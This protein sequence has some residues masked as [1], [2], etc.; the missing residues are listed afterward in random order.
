VK[1]P[2]L[3]LCLVTALALLVPSA[4]FAEPAESVEPTTLDE[5]EASAEPPQE[6]GFGVSVSTALNGEV[7]P[8]RLIAAGL[9]YFDM[10][11]FELG[12]GFHPFIRDE[13]TIVSG[14]F[15]Y[16]LF[17]N[18]RSNKFKTYLL[19]NLSYIY[20]S[21][22]TFYPTSYHYLFLHGGY[23]LELAGFAGSYMDTNVSF[24]G[25]TY[26]KNSQNP[27]ASLLDADSF[28]EDFGFSISFQ[29]SV[30]YRF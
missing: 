2:Y 9:Y 23:G 18:G 26:N 28:F 15:N 17:P 6:S 25:F 1:I 16:K 4:A 12:V 3:M 11:Q 13:Q 14:D 7:L 29:V 30:G 21:R 5:S 27:A 19:A 10:H 20:S 22:E 8:L 24:G